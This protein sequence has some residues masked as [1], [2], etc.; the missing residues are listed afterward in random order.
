MNGQSNNATLGFRNL[1]FLLNVLAFLGCADKKKPTTSTI[2]NP[3]A[4]TSDTNTSQPV[5]NVSETQIYV[6]NNVA[7]SDTWQYSNRVDKEKRTVYKASITSPK[8]LEFEFPYSGG[9]VA[10]LTLRKRESDTHVYIQVS[11]GQF[12]RSF[13]G[14][15]ARIRFDGRPPVNYSFS[16]A[17]NG[18]AN[19]IF[20]DSEKALIKQLKSSR[21]MVVDVEFAGQGTRQIMFRIANLKWNY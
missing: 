16:A 17:E 19:V 21:S 8:L 4:V 2:T 1:V 12:N 5:S 7:G 11:K 14:G 15:N 10:T 13:Q 6:K 9:S 18:S 20:F 3:V